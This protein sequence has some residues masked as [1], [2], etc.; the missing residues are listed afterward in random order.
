MDDVRLVTWRLVLRRFTPADLDALAELHGD[1]EVMRHLDDGRPV[2]RGTVAD[3]TLPALLR[4][5]EELPAGLGCW[6]A[7]ERGA[8]VGWFS[9]R[10]ATSVGLAGG[11]DGGLEIGYRLLPSAW[12][13]GLAT[14]GAR[15]LVRSAFA[16]PAAERVVATT[17]AVNTASRRVLERAGLRYERT[18]HVDWPDPIEG[19]EHGD[20][21]YGLTRGEWAPVHLGA[22]SGSG[23]LTGP[24]SRR[25]RGAPRR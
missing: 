13:R 4:A 12:G 1:P 16:E 22:G 19:A 11:P 25:R 20:V 9:L 17:M 14:E 21:V 18:F 8:F 5:Y 15:A 23:R 6:A 3:R 10:P 7:V 2:P 24:G